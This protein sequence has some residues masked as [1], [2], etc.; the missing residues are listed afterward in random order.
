VKRT[1]LNWRPEALADR[2]TIFTSNAE[3]S[4]ELAQQWDQELEAKLLGACLTP[5]NLMQGRVANTLE[6]LLLPHYVAVIQDS[7][8]QEAIIVLRILHT[9]KPW[10]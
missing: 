7:D 9:H 3:K 10:P 6:L 2:Q 5:H 1:H 8:I 4:Q